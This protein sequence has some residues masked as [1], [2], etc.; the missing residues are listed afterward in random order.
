MRIYEL[1]FEIVNERYDTI[2]MK[3]YVTKSPQTIIWVHLKLTL[4]SCDL[5]SIAEHKNIAY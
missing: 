5:L 2:F 1:K 4:V 3:T